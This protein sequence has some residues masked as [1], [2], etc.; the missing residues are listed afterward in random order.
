MTMANANPLTRIQGHTIVRHMEL[1]VD[2]ATWISDLRLR[3]SSGEALGS[4]SVE[5][6]FED[7]SELCLRGL[8]GGLTQL[9]YLEAE[10]HRPD[11]LD[12]IKFRV[13]ELE[14]DSLSLSCAAIRIEPAGPG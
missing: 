2:P 14:R 6:V 13:K 9:L 7:V 10:D 5:V 3:L 12:R 8:G 4:S 1:V 11:Q